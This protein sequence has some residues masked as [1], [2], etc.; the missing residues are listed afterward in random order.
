MGLVNLQTDLKSL[1]FGTKFSSDRPGSGNSNQPYIDRDIPGV[2]Y[3]NPNQTFESVAEGD[4]PVRSGPDFLLR[5]GF[6]APASLE[7]V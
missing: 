7:S 2:Q 6:L 5:N 1:K 4:L 3:N